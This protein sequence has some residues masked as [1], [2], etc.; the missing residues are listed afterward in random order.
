MKIQIVNLSLELLCGL[1]VVLRSGW[2]ELQNWG[3][4]PDTAH[5]HGHEGQ[6]EDPREEQAG[7]LWGDPEDLQHPQDDPRP[8]HEEYQTERPRRDVQVVGEDRHQRCVQ[9]NCQRHHRRGRPRISVVVS[10]EWWPVAA[11]S[12]S[13][14][15]SHPPSPPTQYWRPLVPKQP[16]R[17]LHIYLSRVAMAIITPCLPHRKWRAFLRRICRHSAAAL[18]SCRLR[19]RSFS[20]SLPTRAAL[21][22]KV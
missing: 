2:K 5:H 6:D 17:L 8:T 18:M 3:R 12:M 21:R 10:F 19:S 15:P 14:S 22:W 13:P 7:D 9:G 1:L 20:W 4:G 11:G 16:Q